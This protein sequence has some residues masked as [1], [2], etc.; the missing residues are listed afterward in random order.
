[1]RIPVAPGVA[2][3]GRHWTGAGEPFLLVH[4]LASNARLWDGVADLLAAAGHAVLAVDQR[5]HGQSDKPDDGYD[6]ETLT[7]DLLAVIDAVALDRPLA[8]GQSWGANVV[9]ELGHRAPGRVRGVALIDGGA[10]DL[11]A[12]LPDWNET[13]RL[14]APPALDG[15]ARADIEAYMRRTHSDWPDAG[16]EGALAN[17]DVKPDG[18]VAPWLTRSRHMTILR[19]LWEHRPTELLP[20][21]T[22][23]VLV[24]AAIDH[25]AHHDIHAQKPHLVA[26]LLLEARRA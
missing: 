13:E 16:I 17:F 12:R 25:D 3:H 21:L 5:G 26:R 23:P 24:V 14:L 6:F 19:H 7:D 18:T 15:V 10:H 9:L 8:V 20:L 22:V 2:L 1:M 4:G 11:S